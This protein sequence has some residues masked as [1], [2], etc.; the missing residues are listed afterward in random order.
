MSQAQVKSIETLSDFRAALLSFCRGASDALVAVQMESQRTLDWLL[1]DQF[2]YWSRQ[3]RE[4]QEKVVQA[5]NDLNRAKLART[6][7]YEK[8]YTEQTDALRKAEL[9]LA[10]AEDKVQRVRRWGHQ[11]RRAI[12]DY[13]ARARQLADKVGGDPPQ[14]IGVMDRL[15]GAL[16]SYL[17]LSAPVTSGT[18]TAGSQQDTNTSSQQATVRISD[19]SAQSATHAAPPPDDGGGRFSQPGD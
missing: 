1:H 11:V 2:S 9:R 17:V 13:Q 4:R 8:D 18:V 3:V 7:G 6:S 15:L 14:I 10:E 5:R 12:D 16:E 19:A